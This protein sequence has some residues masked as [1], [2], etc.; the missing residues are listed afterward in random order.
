VLDAKNIQGNVEAEVKLD[1]Q[2][3][4]EAVKG[5]A[6]AAK[7]AFGDAKKSAADGTNA[8]AA[9]FDKLA[10]R[11][12]SQVDNVNKKI[13][14]MGATAE[15][16]QIAPEIKV[17]GIDKIEAFGADVNAKLLDIKD[18]ANAILLDL[19]ANDSN[20]TPAALINASKEIAALA[21]EAE[22]LARIFQE[23]TAQSTALSLGDV[24]G[25]KALNTDVSFVVGMLEDAGEKIGDMAAA[26]TKI[27]AKPVSA[28]FKEIGVQIA[29][30]Q[31]AMNGDWMNL[32][33]MGERVLKVA[34]DI[35]KSF[36]SLDLGITDGHEIEALD[37]QIGQLL[38]DLRAVGK[39]SSIS[40]GMKAQVKILT[41]A[42]GEY[43]KI[44]GGL[45]AEKTQ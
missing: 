22:G 21:G 18:R 41:S 34:A 25:M 13:S 5:L 36:A 6:E 31:K 3:A 11:A 7:R 20:I 4:G 37:K 44:L 23:V 9:D 2:D 43:R 17:E 38:L 10:A 19:F 27:D 42:M 1:T 16:I 26:L 24:P 15:S 40:D 12:L 8:V 14:A 35:Q 39:D 30:V 45:M 29:S 32:G 33:S 28:A